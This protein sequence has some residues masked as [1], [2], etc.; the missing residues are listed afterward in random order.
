MTAR[1][2]LTALLVLVVGC[3]GLPGGEKPAPPDAPGPEAGYVLDDPAETPEPEAEPE[4]ASKAE[5]EPEPE[6]EPKTEPEPVTVTPTTAPDRNAAARAACLARGGV[7]QKTAAG[8]LVCVTRTDDAQKA[9]TD[10]DQCQGECLARSRTCAPMT[11]LIG[12][13]DIIMASGG[14]AT[15]CID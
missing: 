2:A 15:V 7:F 4:S 13:H 1:L 5:P 14:R 8:G 10:P 11:P 6:P 12:C 3:T 9:C